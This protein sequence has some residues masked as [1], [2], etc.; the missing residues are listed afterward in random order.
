V[1]EVRG[2]LAVEVAAAVGEAL[3]VR[4]RTIRRTPRRRSIQRLRLSRLET[5]GEAED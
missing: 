3:A 2:S 1:R 5:A 4:R